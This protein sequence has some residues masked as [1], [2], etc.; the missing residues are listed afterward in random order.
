[1]CLFCVC[2][3]LDL[4]DLTLNDLRGSLRFKMWRW[5]D[6]TPWIRR[7]LGVNSIGLK[8]TRKLSKKLPKIQMDI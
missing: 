4:Y 8:I 7:E 2:G 5:A 1:M 3:G 6:L